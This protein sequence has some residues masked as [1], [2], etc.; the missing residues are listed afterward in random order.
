M[1]SRT[2][3]KG[4]NKKEKKDEIVCLLNSS[5]SNGHNNNNNK[6]GLKRKKDEQKRFCFFLQLS[7]SLINAEDFHSALSFIEKFL[8][9][10]AIAFRTKTNLYFDYFLF[11]S[12]PPT[13]S[14]ISSVTRLSSF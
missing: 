12:N 2:N 1:L 4:W 5:N 13:C 14:S 7:F 11:M 10:D 6:K 9:A 3:K 8:S